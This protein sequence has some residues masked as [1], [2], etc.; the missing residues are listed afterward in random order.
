MPFRIGVN[1]GRH[2]PSRAEGLFLF[3]SLGAARSWR[4]QGDNFLR[5]VLSEV[6]RNFLRY[7]PVVQ[8]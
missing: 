4:P 3:M 5:L 2:D 8:W 7:W 6:S 1:V